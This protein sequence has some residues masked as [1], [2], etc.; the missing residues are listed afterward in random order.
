ML[1]GTPGQERPEFEVASVKWIDR[2]KMDSDHQGH[3]LTPQRFVD[4][5]DLMQ[6]I[7]MAYIRGNVCTLKASTGADCP[8]IFGD[9]PG[10]VKSERFEIM[11]T[12]PQTNG[13]SSY[14]S[15]Q[16]RAADGS[17]VDLMLQVLLEDRFH[18]RAHR[19]TREIPVYVLTVGKKDLKLK[20][21]ASGS[22]IAKAPDGSSHEV[23]GFR[24]GRRLSSPDG[25]SRM[26]LSFQS[27]SLGEV[28]DFL[29]QQLDR[30]V[31]DRTGLSG[32]YDFTLDYLEDATAPNM[33]GL[34]V[35]PRGVPILSLLGRVTVGILSD[36]FQ[37]L[38]L[39]LE[40]TKS[41]MEVLV[42][43]HVE[44]PSQN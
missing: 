35:G 21:S 41:R 19:E 4:R 12:L 37:D 14:T 7:S 31:L 34:P 13:V 1:V 20:P 36:A 43:D 16:L 33:T 8:F 11:A 18:L 29:G 25:V 5:T 30:P 3:E 2:A 28:A 26:R 44:R 17:D 22:E 42:I 10:W 6:F 24:G 32:D 38:G 15:R 27:S 39:R 9:I 40:A 23:H